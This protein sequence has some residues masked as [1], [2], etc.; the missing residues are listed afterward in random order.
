MVVIIA[1]VVVVG[2]ADGSVDAVVVIVVD[3]NVLTGVAAVR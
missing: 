1:D 2:T 3:V